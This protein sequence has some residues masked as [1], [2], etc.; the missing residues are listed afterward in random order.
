MKY[1]LLM[2]LSSVATLQTSAQLAV[3]EYTLSNGL[4]VWL[5]EDHSQPKVFGSVVVRAGAKDTPDTGIAHYFE[6]I[7][8]KGNDH[9]GTT[10]YAAEKV[11]L[12]SIA[13]QYDLLAQTQEA[14]ARASIQTK[15]NQISIRAAEYAIPNEF[16]R[17]ITKYGGSGLNA[18]TSYDDTQYFNTFSPQ[19][20]NQW[21]EI[22]SERFI[23]P[24][25]RLFQSELE[26]VYEEKNMY[27]DRMETAAMHKA[28]ELFF[29]PHPYIYPI[30]GS[31]QNLKNPRLSQ[32][33][34]FYKKYY[35]ASNMGLIISGDFNADQVF[36]L[37]EAKFSRI[38][39]GVAPNREMPQPKPVIGVQKEKIKIPIPFIKGRAWAWRGVP[40]NHAD[41]IALNIAVGLLN[42]ANGTGFLDRLMVNG[43][44][45]MAQ[46]ISMSLNDA[47]VLAVL[48]VPNMLSLS[49]RPAVK[50]V[51]QAIERIKQGDFSDET[52]LSLKL[53]QRRTF[54]QQIE[55]IDSRAAKMRA[56]YS[57]GG[58]W[59]K[60]LATGAAI[61]ALTKEDIIRIARTYFN[62]NYFEVT[63]KTGRYP[64]ERVT[65]PPYA[66]IPVKNNN[67][68]SKYAQ[69][70]SAIPTKEMPPRFLDFEK[71]VQT[72]PLSP[73]STLY[74]QE[75]K[76]N[77]LFTI[78]FQF[79]IGV[80]E[81]P[82]LTQLATYLHLLGT[83]KFIYEQFR[84]ALQNL[85]S[86]LTFEA[87]NNYFVITVTGFDQKA[88]ETL[89]WVH[90]FFNHVQ[91]DPKKMKPILDNKKVENKS[92]LKTP[93]NTMQA[94]MQK[95]LYG[96][97]SKY[98][99]QLSLSKIKSLKGED[100]I[101]LFEKVLQT[102]CAIH[103][104][105]TLPAQTI[106]A[107]ITQC[108]IPN[109]V[110]TPSLSPL[111]RPS[112]L[113]TYP[114][115]FIVDDPKATQ[116]IIYAYIAGPQN[117][118]EHER[119]AANLF[120]A[121]F[122]RGMSSLLFQEIRELRSFAYGTNS[123]FLLP[124]PKNSDKNCS[125]IAALSTQADK[126]VSA[127]EVLDSLL[128]NMPIQ[129]E[130]FVYAKQNVAN[131][132]TNDYP[133]FRDISVR[134]ASLKR[135]GYDHDPTAAFL[136][137]LPQMQMDD[138]ELFYKNHIQGQ[139]VIW[140]IVGNVK[141]L[142]TAGLSKFGHMVQYRQKD[143]FAN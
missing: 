115:L 33:I 30:I 27:D 47:G 110:T 53:E 20:I 109:H 4:T 126:T 31:T 55:S 133:E 24:V 35:V 124:Q 137:H 16:T 52:F 46:A 78:K 103:Y 22:A 69:S 32:M 91:A 77:Q 101:R 90:T 108:D 21:I 34:D 9:I 48:V 58:S 79:G 120:N 143:I 81:Q 29:A 18:G 113:Y 42:N 54:E 6:H 67:V 105:G 122:G 84:N 8:F 85:G 135:D 89:Q 98:L 117:L 43:K 106:A 45:M 59:E 13:A 5:N 11:L 104:S 125:F 111:F 72:I 19:Y 134:I 141:K 107:L 100:L 112:A 51:Q 140:M 76:I 23:N 83:D 71:D 1:I 121:Y 102:E 118:T 17:L 26:T 64:K 40:A 130:R 73:L 131:T 92:F 44:V 132:L 61:E 139:P 14:G 93:S 123:S 119:Y 49:S 63:K 41:E 87:E 80:L 70:L 88:A 129:Q 65:K 82:A 3:K 128:K 57:L 10:D 60:H 95:V 12:D 136:A 2:L 142:N 66:P 50:A 38:P 127:M 37:I 116:S 75:N 97:E 62:D 99:R 39:A 15:I 36:P 86:T 7:M 138:I 74:L 56:L 96:Q 68:E 114:T 25:F 94:L 28:L